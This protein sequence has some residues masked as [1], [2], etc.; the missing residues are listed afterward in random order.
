MATVETVESTI[1]G[2][3]LVGRHVQRHQQRR[4]KDVCKKDKQGNVLDEQEKADED[5]EKDIRELSN[6]LCPVSFNMLLDEVQ[7][8]WN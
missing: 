5:A 4:V 6:A 2:L 3:E 1:T 7:K 8:D